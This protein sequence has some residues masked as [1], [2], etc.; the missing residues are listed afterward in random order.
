MG[1][2]LNC[3]NPVKA[4]E[5]L[6]EIFA[7]TPDDNKVPEDQ[8]PAKNTCQGKYPTNQDEDFD[9][10]YEATYPEQ[11]NHNPVI[12]KNIAPPPEMTNLSTNLMNEENPDFFEDINNIEDNFE[13]MKN[14]VLRSKN[15]SIN[16]NITK[17]SVLKSIPEQ[18]REKGIPEYPLDEEVSVS[19]AEKDEDQIAEDILHK[20]D[21]ENGELIPHDDFD[22]DG[23]RE[24][25]PNEADFF[26]WDGDGVSPLS[27]QIKIYNK[28]DP[29]R[30]MVYRGDINPENDTR[31]GFGEC[32]TREGALIGTWRNDQFTGWGRET[33]RG[34]EG[35]QETKFING[36]K[37]DKRKDV[38]PKK[39]TTYVGDY[40]G[41]TR[42]GVGVLD[43]P[44]YHYEGE[45]LNGKLDG[46]G[47][48]EYKSQKNIYEG[49]FRN[50][51]IEGRGMFQY[52]NGDVYEGE[53]SQGKMHGKGV[54]KYANGDVYTGDYVNGKKHGMGEIRTKDGK[55]WSGM[56]ENGKKVRHPAN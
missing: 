11:V 47:R 27:D 37:Q 8:D 26:I 31:H 5:E 38:L 51:Q 7:L 25:Y 55:K 50:G 15:K 36:Q 42:E 23:W 41:E 4:D 10:S 53:M 18:N 44:K 2:D 3:C 14:D 32:F 20:F 28:D 17:Q 13:N 39:Q 43:T 35:Y 48:I 29:Y 22:R 34:G 19:G 12:I 9:F 45:F 30:E 21:R 49:E 52:F 1:Q 16:S 40:R 56:F 46:N 33:K 24:L 6:N 54:Y